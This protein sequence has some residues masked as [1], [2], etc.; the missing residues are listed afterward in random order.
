[1]MLELTEARR[2][3]AV[4]L[5]SGVER[6]SGGAC[7]APESIVKYVLGLL[8]EEE[9]LQLE[10]HLATCPDCRLEAIALSEVIESI[11]MKA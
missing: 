6:R 5:T 4:T 1:M 10:G 3:D 2:M 7:P 8:E 9:R 11:P